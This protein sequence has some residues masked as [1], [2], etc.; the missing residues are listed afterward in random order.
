MAALFFVLEKSPHEIAYIVSHDHVNPRAFGRLGR[1]P[2][3]KPP[4][5]DMM[6][7]LSLQWPWNGRKEPRFKRKQPPN[8]PPGYSNPLDGVGIWCLP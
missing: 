8:K 5:A 1:T 3:C 4:L 6:K 7:E 2:S